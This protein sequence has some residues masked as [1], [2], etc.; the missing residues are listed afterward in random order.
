MTDTTFTGAEARLATALQEVQVW[1]GKDADLVRAG[2]AEH[3]V[4]V[5]EADLS[6]PLTMGAYNPRIPSG[7]S[8]EINLIKQAKS[9]N[10]I[11]MDY[12]QS[13][14]VSEQLHLSMADGRDLVFAN[15][16]GAAQPDA[17]RRELLVEF[18]LAALAVNPSMKLRLGVHNE[19]CG[20]ANYF[21]N[22]KMKQ[23]RSLPDGAQTE[24][25]AM[26]ALLDETYQALVKG[27][28]VESSM[29]K[30]LSVIGPDHTLA[31]LERIY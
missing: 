13:G 6:T 30:Y 25:A 15:A 26:L 5:I 8:A 29:E 19:I 1:F 3:G 12:R 4:A 23:L 20:G 27:G 16:G 31:K 17:K 22:G 24:R 21:T 7:S 2:A 9:L 10:C 11:C 18:L 28:V 14:E